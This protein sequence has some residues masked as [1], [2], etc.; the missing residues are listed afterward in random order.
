MTHPE[1]ICIWSDGTY[2]AYEDLNEYAHMSDDYKLIEFNSPEW[3]EW[4][5]FTMAVFPFLRPVT[6][7]Q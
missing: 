3:H 4:H 1:S 2:C 5:S 6:H 7:A